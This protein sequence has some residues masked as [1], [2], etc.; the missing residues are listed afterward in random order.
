MILKLKSLFDKSP[1]AQLERQLRAEARYFA[2]VMR[3]RLTQLGVCYRY[4]KSKKD[5]LDRAVQEVAFVK[6]VGTEEAIYIM[7]DTM[8]L[9]RGINM[10]ALAD[11]QVLEDLSTVC[12]RPVKFKHRTKSGAW[13]IVERQS[14]VGG[15]PRNQP[16]GDMLDEWPT[17]SRKPLLVPLGV[18]A[19]RGLFYRS[20]V[21]FP[22]ALIGGATGA[23]KSTFLHGWICA[24]ILHNT[25]NDLRL[26]LVDLKG[27]TEFTRYKKLPHMMDNDF[28]GIDLEAGGFVKRTD[29]VVPLLGFLQQE[30]DRR[31]ARFEK[32]GGIQSLSVWNVRRRK[33]KLP[34]LVLFVDELAVI[35]L[36][37]ALK[38]DARRLLAD[39]TARGR[40]PGV[41]VVL[42]T[43]RP[44]VAVVPG[45]IKGNTDARFAFRV[46]DNASSMVI[47]DSTEAARFDDS[48]PLGRYI[49][50]SGLEKVELQAPLITD[51][52][53][54]QYVKSVIEP[55]RDIQET[56]NARI[57]PE[58]IFKFSI[59]QLGGNFSYRALYEALEGQVSAEYLKQLGQDYEG[60]VLEINGDLYELNAG[61]GGNKPRML[62]LAEGGSSA[63]SLAHS[64]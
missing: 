49:Y 27:G 3:R 17:T 37:P 15:V 50:R 57:P 33:D 47:L 48:T 38:K 62:V 4:P 55:G 7:V 58:E 63:E 32:A 41:H 52:Q 42:A 19:N 22:H 26:A 2:D 16:F 10:L 40:A 59:E 44:E 25:P 39:I 13:F 54:A 30:M 56:G 60:Q 12:R 28:V 51:G 18:G 14:G 8:A 20:M 35:M 11:E 46:T 53:I 34:R 45:L 9:P 61:N 6:A 21:E 31:L 36:D 64:A 1:D 43:Q 5:F 24:L 23:G 29:D